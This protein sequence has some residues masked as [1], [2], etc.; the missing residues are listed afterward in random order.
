[1]ATLF[2]FAHE[3]DAGAVQRIY[4]PFC[5]S[6][7]IS[8]EMQAPSVAE[9]AQ[10][11]ARIAAR[12]PWLVCEREG[13]IAGYAYA[14]PHR[15][16]AAYQWSVD[17]TVYIGADH[18]RSGVGRGLYTTLLH[19]LPLLGYYKAYA[20]VTLP[21]P[22]SEGLHR[23]VGFEPVG[24]YRGVGYKMGRWHDVAWF[25]RILQ[26]ETVEPTPPRRMA[27]VIDSTEVCA[28]LRAGEALVRAS[29]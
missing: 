16:R 19:I 11:I 28:A 3:G 18:W 25:Q 15:E 20:G 13:V 2:R 9:M 26:P 4:A 1:M 7:P 10:R 17:M 21:N 24:V 23:A 14:S 12:L 27:E 8:F 5:E 6:T 29:S 22:A